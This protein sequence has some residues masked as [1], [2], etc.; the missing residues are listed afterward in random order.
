M[1]YVCNR[2]RNSVT[3]EMTLAEYE[4]IVLIFGYATGAAMKEGEKDLA[5]GWL[6]FANEMNATNPGWTPYNIP[7][8]TPSPGSVDPV[9]VAIKFLAK[10]SGLPPKTVQASLEETYRVAAYN[11]HPDR[12]GGSHELFVQLQAHYRTLKAQGVTQWR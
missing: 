10:H 11:L 4:R 5:Y 12:L 8:L 9:G 3:L 7:A 2:E 6:A 1:T